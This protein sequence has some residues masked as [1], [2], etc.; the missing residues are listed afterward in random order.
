MLENIILESDV[1]F[2]GILIIFFLPNSQNSF[3]LMKAHKEK[4]F[5]KPCSENKSD[6]KLKVC[7]FKSGL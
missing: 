1:T 2:S 5:K 4:T 7:E 6:K 3:F